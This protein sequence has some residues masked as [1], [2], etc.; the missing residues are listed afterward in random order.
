MHGDL[1]DT[2]DLVL[3]RGRDEIVRLVIVLAG[4]TEPRLGVPDVEDVG[5]LTESRDAVGVCA[6]MLSHG[7]QSSGAR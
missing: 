5:V 7:V 3:T 1:A 6:G 4:R 2:T